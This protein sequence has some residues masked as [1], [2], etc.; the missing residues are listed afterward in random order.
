[1][2]VQHKYFLMALCYHMA[3]VIFGGGWCETINS[4]TDEQINVDSGVGKRCCRQPVQ[5]CHDT[6]AGR[7]QVYKHSLTTFNITAIHGT[8]IH[9]TCMQRNH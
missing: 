7:E 2:H 5:R 9:V 8:I 6:V 3:A 4:A 1:M